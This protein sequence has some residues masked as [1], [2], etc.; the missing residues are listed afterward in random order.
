MRHSAGSLRLFACVILGLIVAEPTRTAAQ[1]ECEVKRRSCVTGCHARYFSID[2]KRNACIAGC[3]NEAARC[4]REQPS[5]QGG[6]RSPL[7]CMV[8]GR[9]VSHDPGALDGLTPTDDVT[10]PASR[11]C[12][13]GQGMEWSPSDRTHARGG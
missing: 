4:A 8:E 7:S 3:A 1:T 13:P 12:E 5:Q 6:L 10:I 11:P 2:P 9:T